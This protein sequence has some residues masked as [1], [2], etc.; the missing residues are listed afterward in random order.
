MRGKKYKTDE[1]TDSSKVLARQAY[2]SSIY[3]H[4]SN[5]YIIC[6]LSFTKTLP[7]IEKKTTSKMITVSLKK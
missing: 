7:S 3:L 2:I 1:F 6:L 4:K 5:T